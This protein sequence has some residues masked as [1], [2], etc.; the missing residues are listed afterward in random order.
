MVSTG[1]PHD[2][3]PAKR[4]FTYGT[5]DARVWVPD[6]KGLWSAMWLLPASQESRREIEVFEILGNDPTTSIM[7]L[8]PSDRSAASPAKTA[9]LPGV[10]FSQGWHDFRLD[11]RPRSLT[12]TID[13]HRV[14]RLTGR[15]VPDKPM[16]LIIDLAVGGDYPGDPSWATRF[17]ATLAVDRVTIT[18]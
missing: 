6:G 9:K 10:D 14:L 7:H 13:G 16:Y 15:Q 11:W 18:G 3:K 1:P 8:H 2:G 4:A 5:V 17:P 12:F